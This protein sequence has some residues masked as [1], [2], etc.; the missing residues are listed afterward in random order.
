MPGSTKTFIG[1]AGHESLAR[2]DARAVVAACLERSRA[3]DQ[4][5]IVVFDDDSGRPIDLDLELDET[6]LVKLLDPEA[7][8]PKPAGRGRP[9]LGVVSRE[10][11]LLPRHWE[12]L[13]DQRGGASATLRRLVEQARKDTD[14]A[15]R[16]QRTIDAAH[17]F[18]WD[19][20][21]DLP[22]FEEA[23]RS[24]YARDFED[25]ERRSASWPAGIREQLGRYLDRARNLSEPPAPA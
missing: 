25:L 13:A 21:G 11:S 23:T 7:A 4:R 2:G 5:R 3:G 10:V 1:F 16:L 20:A 15:T 17:R 12:W 6:T 9:R 24:L 14:G 22:D 18:L 8:A 19:L